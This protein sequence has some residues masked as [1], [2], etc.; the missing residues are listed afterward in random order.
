MTLKK[1]AYCCIK[2]PNKFHGVRLWSVFLGKRGKETV[3]SQRGHF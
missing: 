3:F 2:N 1:C